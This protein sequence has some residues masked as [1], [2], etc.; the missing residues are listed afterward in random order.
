MQE[1]YRQ[2]D[3]FMQML[4]VA[5]TA[6]GFFD[7]SLVEGNF[8]IPTLNGWLLGYPVVYLVTSGTVEG[9]A[10]YLSSQDLQRHILKASC[11]GLK[12]R[13]SDVLRPT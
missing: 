5:N 4:H 8:I 1:V 6:N 3:S 7:I 9:T 13:L 2:V 12:V 11:P 10:D